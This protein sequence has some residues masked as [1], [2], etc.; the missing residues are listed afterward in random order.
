MKKLSVIV[1]VV[2][3]LTIAGL[4][5]AAKPKKRTRNANR[6]G[7][8][9]ALLVGQARYTGDQSGLEQE[10]IDFFGNRNDPTRDISV[11]SETEDIGYQATFGFR[12]NR[13]FA[14]ELG[15][16]QFGEL[17]STVRGEIDQGDGFIPANV[18]FAFNVGGPLISAVGILPLGEKAEIYARAGYL[19]AS[20]EREIS[21]RV[22]GQNGGAS[23]AKG[24][25]QEAV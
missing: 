14:A 5:E 25:S 7:A 15:L 2:L 23:S 19:F 16:V 4:A 17:S 21:A 9:G 13:Y 6:V 11:S 20:S 8:Y 24:D 1:L 18:K 3:S 10:L 12:F 22:D